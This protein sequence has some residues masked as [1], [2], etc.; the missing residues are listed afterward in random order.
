MATKRKP[1]TPT[2]AAEVIGCHPN[3]VRQMINEGK[4]AAT[5]VAIPGGYYYSI[6]PADVQRVAANPPTQHGT[7]RGSKRRM[8]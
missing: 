3:R 1:L 8:A 5:K 6:D 7:P 4:L 2:Q